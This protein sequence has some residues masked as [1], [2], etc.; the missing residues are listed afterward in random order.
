MS[1]KPRMSPV[2]PPYDEETG[3]LL[4]KWMPPGSDMEPL[5]LFRLLALHRGLTGRLHP[6]ASGLLNHGVLP[7]RDREIVISRIT[8]RAGAEYEWGVHAVVSGPAA[9]LERELLDAFVTQPADAA[10]F[11]AHTRLLVTAVDELHDQATVRAATWREL[12]VIYDDAQLVELL[13]LTGWYRT[14]ST[15]ITSV[16]LPLESWAARFPVTSL[17]S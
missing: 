2:A 14:L 12:Q 1:S 17:P 16:A 4:A 10:V 11:D 9:G 5:L 13:V 6:M 8:A 15:V 7:P 3:R